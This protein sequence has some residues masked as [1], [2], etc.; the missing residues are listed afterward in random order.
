[1]SNLIPPEAR[2][3]IITEY[4]MR[5]A[6][7]WLV[8]AAMAACTVVAFLL[9]TYV[10][11]N[12]QVQLYEASAQEASAQVA[13][14]DASAKAL[15]AASQ[16]ARLIVEGARRRPVLSVY[17]TV[18][19]IVDTYGVQVSSY[20]FVPKEAQISEV[21]IEGVADTRLSLAG[22][23]DALAANPLIARVDLPI[24]NLAKD[25]DISFSLSLVIATTTPA[26]TP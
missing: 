2:K 6:S 11:V 25:R 7:V 12:S 10:L 4:W 15:V 22:F 3:K 24:S 23:R 1:M 8:L 17:D 16:Q 26:T 14:Y 9:P 18:R 5:V 19:D 13:S 21:K 20:Q